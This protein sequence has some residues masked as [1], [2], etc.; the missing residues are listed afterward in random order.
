MME[1]D[2]R[3][4][5]I[6]LVVTDLDGTLLDADKQINDRAKQAIVRLMEAGIAFT[7]ITGRPRPSIQRFSES[8]QVTAPIISCN[9]A[10]IYHNDRI[11]LSRDFSP[12]RLRP[13]LERAVSMG[14]T[15]LCCEGD[16]EFAFSRTAWTDA[17]LHFAIRRPEDFDWNTLR[18]VKANIIN[19]GEP[20]PFLA[21]ADQIQEMESE[22]SITTY[23]TAGAEIIAKDVD[24]ATGLKWL[25]GYLGLDVRQAMACGDNEN[26]NSMLREA[27]IGIAVANACQ[28]TQKHAD[29]VSSAQRTDGV[30]EAIEALL[31]S[32]ICR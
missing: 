13:L 21:L 10:V 20:E 25:C 5:D 7:F 26:D 2:R 29:Y 30:T 8:V 27:G 24:K 4:R 28:S 18:L 12:L 6:Q 32:R 19:L 14:M 3:A 9:G 11:L 23:G 16:R 17:R 1:L 31:E 22:F 15:V